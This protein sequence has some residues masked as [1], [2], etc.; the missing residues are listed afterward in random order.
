MSE[1][2]GEPL[3]YLAAVKTAIVSRDEIRSA[4]V[5]AERWKS[6]LKTLDHG[7]KQLLLS[8]R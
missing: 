7:V 6:L 1:P 3:P 5:D 8:S 4:I 2:V